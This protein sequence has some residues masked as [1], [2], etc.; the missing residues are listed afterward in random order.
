MNLGVGVYQ[1]GAGKVP[2]LS[3]V[4]KAEK[5]FFDKGESK[6]YLPIDGVVAYRKEV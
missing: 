2:M 4:R 6:S 3:V 5:L 1:D